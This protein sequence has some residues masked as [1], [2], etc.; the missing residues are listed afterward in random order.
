MK[1]KDYI[2]VLKDIEQTQK[3]HENFAI[4]IY[5]DGKILAWILGT[6]RIFEIHENEV[7]TEFFDKMMTNPKSL[8]F[9]QEFGVF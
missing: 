6:S 4:I 3:N 1:L 7:P 5:F 8:N 2:T 9:L